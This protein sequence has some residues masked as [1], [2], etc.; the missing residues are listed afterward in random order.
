MKYVLTIFALLILACGKIG[1]PQVDIKMSDPIEVTEE[2]I[3]S[4]G[5]TIT[6]DSGELDG[7][8]INFPAGA[9]DE[10]T[11]ITVSYANVEEGSKL[12]DETNIVSKILILESNKDTQF[13]KPVTITLPYDTELTTHNEFINAYEYVIADNKMNVNG[14]KLDKNE[15]RLEVASKTNI[16]TTAG[17]GS[18]SFMVRHF[19]DYLILEWAKKVA[20]IMAT[21]VDFNYDTGFSPSKDGWFIPN[22]GSIINPG[23]NCIGM[24]SFAKWFF[25]WKSILGDTKG[26]HNKY[27]HG[28][29]SK[30]EDDSCAIEIASR[31]QLGEAAIWTRSSSE[32]NAVGIS[33]L[34][35]AK[36]FV[37]AMH[38][39]GQP[40][41]LYLAQKYNDNTL[42]GAHAV[43][44]YGYANGSFKIYD[45]NHVGQEK[46]V[47]YTYGANW[48]V[49]NSGTSAASSRFKYN[50]F[51]IIGT[52]LFHG[53]SDAVNIYT[54]AEKSP[55]FGDSSLFPTITLDEPEEDKDGN[56][57][58]TPTGT[59]MGTTLKGTITG[60]SK[61]PTHTNIYV[62][63]TRYGVNLTNSGEFEQKVPLFC[64][65]GT[66]NDDSTINLENKD[67]VIEFLVTEANEWEKY[68]GYGRYIVSCTGASPVAKVTLT[69]DTPLDIDLHIITPDATEIYYSN[70]APSGAYPYLDYDDTTGTGPEH[71]FFEADKEITAGTYTVKVKYFSKKTYEEAPIVAYYITV[72]S[73]YLLDGVPVYDYVRHY[74]GTLSSVGEK[75]TVGTFE[76][77]P[78]ADKTLS[79]TPQAL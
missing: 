74:S 2:T 48:G 63:G 27:R 70:K 52:S 35:V 66:A 51:G 68:A 58:V 64:A 41:I 9:V 30:W 79:D 22:Y 45:P 26:L 25:T 34:E 78:E 6:I 16:S 40:Q 20:D 21:S 3:T 4:T 54:E 37:Q 7:L 33:S 57:K 15:K 24:S 73:G 12:P 71:I 75:P 43:L 39:T 18:V 46:S 69:W 44:I 77:D 53:F 62:N 65:T 8:I 31:M 60:G 67:N 23:G 32:M 76:F 1:T 14:L 36:S 19:S 49:Y 61:K 47:T 5:G 59:E 10:D 28:D 17:F 50:Y 13:S 29:R 42:G 38:D 55:C 56:R 11:K 72:E